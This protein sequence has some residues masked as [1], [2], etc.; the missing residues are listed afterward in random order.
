MEVEAWREVEW[1]TAEENMSRKIFQFN[2]E[3]AFKIDKEKS[4]GF[5]KKF[6]DLSL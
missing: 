3:F 5:G 6:Y 2:R 4:F 1:D